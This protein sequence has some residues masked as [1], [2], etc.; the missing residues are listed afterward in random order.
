MFEDTFLKLYR[1]T[2]WSL[3]RF[4]DH[5]KLLGGGG[6]GGLPPCGRKPG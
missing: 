1:G 5:K 2:L 3:H 4:D 6:G